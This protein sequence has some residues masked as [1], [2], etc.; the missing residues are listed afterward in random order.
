M[1]PEIWGRLPWDLIERIV[2]FAD[3]DTRRALGIPPGR[4][5]KSS[6]VARPLS[7]TTFRYF[8][9][10]KKLMKLTFGESYEWEVYDEIE[11]AGDAWAHGVNGRHRG[12]WRGDV[13]DEPAG[14]PFK[15]W[16]ANVP[17]ITQSDVGQMPEI[18]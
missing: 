8:P 12:V 14:K 11:P 9:A 10:A 16:F 5:A 7:P 18:L 3:I 13:Y 15:F 4:L 1:D 6:L 2:S 17:E